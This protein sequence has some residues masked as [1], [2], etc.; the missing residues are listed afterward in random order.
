M[1]SPVRPAD[2]SRAKAAAFKLSKRYGFLHPAQMAL[3]DIAWDRGVVVSPGRLEGS[4]AR[5]VRKG[6][7]GTI[8]V[9]AG[10]GEMGRRRFSIAHELG[11][12]EL[13]E[14]SQWFVCSS[15]NL[16]DYKKSPQEAEANTFAAELLMPT[17]HVRPRCEN[18]SPSL[19]LVKS[20]A[21]DF[22]VSLTAAGIRVVHL[23]KQ[24][25]ILVASKDR[26]VSWWIPKGDRFGVWLR[27][28]HPLSQ[29]T[30]AWNAFDGSVG[31][32]EVE[33]VSTD[34][35]FPDRP[36][37]VEF[38]VSEQSMFLPRFGIVLTLLTFGD[39][40]DE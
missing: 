25:C 22:Q 37:G 5:I 20:I 34:A 33:D 4:E 27:K 24:E 18:S 17:S 38:G 36:A 12:W 29:E 28:G 7:R 23:T 6:S 35:W 26:R 15:A 9:R 1:I 13:H 32:E 31:G 3:E 19:E 11:H 10:T 21:D 8:R 39:A 14:E 2:L 40:E 30:L 16:R